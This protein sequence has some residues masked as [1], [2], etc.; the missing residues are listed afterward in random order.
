MKKLEDNTNNIEG[1]KGRKNK[2][3]KNILTPKNIEIIVQGIHSGKKLTNNN[4]KKK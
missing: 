3:I 4:K 2:D 1:N